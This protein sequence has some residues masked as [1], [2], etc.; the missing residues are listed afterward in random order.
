MIHSVLSTRDRLPRLLS[1]SSR[2]CPVSLLLVY[3]ERRQYS[4]SAQATVSQKCRWR[5]Q[6][7]RLTR[8]PGYRRVGAT[9]DRV[10]HSLRH[11]CRFHQACLG[12][13]VRYSQ[14]CLD[15]GGPFRRLLSSRSTSLNPSLILSPPLHPLHPHFSHGTAIPNANF[16]LYTRSTMASLLRLLP[17][18]LPRSVGARTPE[19]VYPR[20]IRKHPEL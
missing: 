2:L 9:L 12:H 5:F 3:E 13:F 1:S 15:D 4:G 16:D 14:T 18:S 8:Y 20:E 10:R 17:S 6:W 11:H 7:Q 19:S